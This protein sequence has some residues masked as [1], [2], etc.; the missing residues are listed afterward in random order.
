MCGKCQF[1]C[2]TLDSS[3]YI[4]D[5]HDDARGKTEAENAIGAT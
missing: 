5:Y 3:I 2:D 1:A 4:R